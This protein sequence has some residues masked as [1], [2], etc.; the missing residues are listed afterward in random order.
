VARLC[1]Q[2]ILLAQLLPFMC[3][4]DCL[5]RMGRGREEQKEKKKKEKLD[6]MS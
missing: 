3:N 5:V 2:E 6:V 4:V 1:V